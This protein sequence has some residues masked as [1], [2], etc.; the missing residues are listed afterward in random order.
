MNR[1]ALAAAISCTIA[2][3]E[4]AAAPHSPFGGN[5]PGPGPVALFSNGGFENGNL[6]SWTAENFINNGV[7]YPTVNG[8]TVPPQTVAN[9]NLGTGGVANTAAV[10]PAAALSQQPNG[11]S[12]TTTLRWPIY[13]S[14]SAVV[15]GQHDV[16]QLNG[17][18]PYGANQ[19]VNSVK[20]DMV[21]ASTDVD[22][23]DGLAHVRFLVAPVLQNP[24]HTTTQQ[25]Y[26][27]LHVKNLTTGQELFDRFNYVSQ[28]GVPWQSDAAG[29]IEYLAWQAIDVAA[30]GQINVGDDVQA[31]VIASG[32]S[33]GGHWGEAYVDQF[34][35]FLPGIWVVARQPQFANEGT[36]VT[37]AYTVNNAAT[38]AMTNVVVTLPTPN[39]ATFVSFT[40]PASM[41]CTG[42][43]AAGATG[44]ISCTIASMSPFSSVNFSIV[45]Q[46]NTGLTLPADMGNG[47]YGVQS[48][49]QQFLLGMPATTYLTDPA[50]IQ[51]ADYS[52]SIDDG[53]TA[54]SAGQA[55][56]YTVVVK[57][58]GPATPLTN[59]GSV[60]NTKVTETN[61]TGGLTGITWTCT[62]AGTSGGKSSACSAASGSGLVSSNVQLVAGGTATFVVKATAAAP[63]T[64]SFV[65]NTVSVSTS[66]LP[67]GYGDPDSANNTMGDSDAFGTLVNLTVDKD[68]SGVG[69]GLVSSA[70]AGISCASACTTQTAPF[71]IGVQVTLTAVADSGMS[72][73]S[74]T[75]GPCSGSTNPQCSFT[76]AAAV[77][78][79]AKFF[80]PSYAIT[81]TS[82]GNGAL[83]CSTPVFQGQSSTCTISPA[84][85][86]ALSSLTDNG[87]SVLGSVTGGNTYLISNVQAAHTVVAGF[88]KTQ[89]TLCG[90][91]SECGSGNCVDGVCCN[92]SCSGQCQACNVNAGGITPGTCTTISGA[93]V[94]TR[95]ACTSDGSS[96]GGACDGT[97]ATACAYPGASTVCRAASCTSGTQTSAADCNGTGTCPASAT[98]ACSPYVCGATACKISCSTTSDC[99][100]G[101]YCNSSGQCVPTIANG[102]ICSANAQCTNGNCV[103]GV[104]CNSACGAEC[105]ACD[106]A[107]AVGFCSPVSGA[108]HGARAACATDGSSCGGSCD[109]VNVTACA[110][111]TAQ[112]RGA[113]CTGSTETLAA[114]CSG[115]SC[116]AVQTQS[117]NAYVCGAT[118]CKT[119]CGSS[120]DCIAG[121]YCNSSSQC[122]PTIA[123]GGTCSAN[124]QCTNGNCVDGVCCNSACGGECQAC[125]V[126]GA[127]GVCSPVTGAP[128]GSRA[129]CATDGSSCGGS[130]DGTNVSA[131]TYPTT[132]CRSASCSGTTETL[133]ASC[134]GGSCPAVQTQSC[135]TYVCGATAC[136]TSCTSSSDCA[137]GDYCSTGQCV[138]KVVDGGSCSAGSQCTSGYCTDG[139]C[140]DQACNGQCQAC[141]V[142][143]SIGACTTVTT[144]APHGTRAACATDGSSCGGTCNG[145][146]ATACAYPTTACRNASCTSGTATL[147]ASCDG[148]G[149]CP[150]LQ[151]Q[152]CT[153]YVCGATACAG[154][155]TT[156]LDCA[157][158]SWCS[159]GVCVVKLADGSS[160]GASSQCSNGNCVDG[161]C[162]NSAC[163]GQC[164]ACNV[165]GSAGT[166]TAVSGSPHGARTACASD[167][168]ACGG[169]CDGTVRTACAYPGGS[170]TCRA[171]SCTSGVATLAAACNGSGSCPALQTQGCN[172][173]VCGPTACKGNCTVDTD[174]IAGDFCAGGVCAPKLVNGA[175]C[176]A[177]SQCASGQ[178]VDG[179]CCNVVCDGQCEACDVAGSAGTC[180]AVS[181]A[182][183]GVRAACA[184]DGSAC[185]GACNGI[186]INA[187]AFPTVAC[188]GASCALGVA[189]LAAA[190]DGAGH[191]P[192]VQTQTC[193]PYV[194]GGNACAGNCAQPS[195]CAPGDYCAGG[196]CIP[197]LPPG[198]SCGSDA[199]CG[200]GHCV[201]GV[202]CDTACTGQ[203]E[204]CN[205]AGSAGVCSP[206]V[207]AP[208]DGRAACATDGSTCGGA[209]DGSQ[210]AA[211]TYPGSQ[212]RAET[213]CASGVK[214]D[215][216]SCDG[217]GHCPARVQESC[218]PATCTT[219]A[220]CSSSDYC[221]AGTCKPR[222]Q[223]AVAGAGGCTSTGAAA[224]PLLLIVFAFAL[225][226]RKAAL[227]AAV[228]LASGARAQTVSTSFTVD[229]FQPGAGAFDVLG[230]SSPETAHDL[231]WHASAFADYARDPLR[232]IPVG[233]VDPT[234]PSQVRLLRNQSMLHLGGSVGF[235]DNLEIGA[236][237]PIALAQ[238]S[239]SAPMLGGGLQNGVASSG[240]GDLRLLPKIRLFSFG[241][242]VL[243]ASLPLSLPTGRSDAFLSQGS[244]TATPTALFELQRG[245]PVR[246]VANAGVILRSGKQLTN[247]DV[248]NALAYGLAGE[249]PFAVRSQN[250]AAMATLQGEANFSKGGSVERPMELMAAM[251]WTPLAG[252]DLV[253]GGGPGL[254]NG[255]GTPRYRMFFSFAFTPAVLPSRHRL[256]PPPV[257]M[258]AM[259]VPPV[260]VK[261]DSPTIILS[262]PQQS[263]V[264]LVASDLI[265]EE[266][267][268]AKLDTD[269]GKIDL[270]APV[271]FK[272][273]SDV[274]LNESRGVLDSAVTVLQAHPEISRIRIEGHTDN[275]G[276]PAYN[277]VLSQRRATSVLRYLVRHGIAAKR[278][279]ARGFGEEH[280]VA[281]NAT[282]Q[283]RAINR[284]VELLILMTKVASR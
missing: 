220:D 143:S 210:R 71:A 50:V 224:W 128:H 176:S 154:N 211:C 252:L 159:G 194:C 112:C 243:G 105:Q 269:S 227:L 162:C 177:Q 19:N 228:A 216:A 85:G 247:L 99:V 260:L 21:V 185:G 223:W 58:A 30:A 214:T 73:G 192:A 164:E 152:S 76:P 239:G 266:P 163:G 275:Q 193:A 249:L 203:C 135:N 274:L 31:Q 226:R 282:E 284:R 14:Y 259:D 273:D 123:N 35:S 165:A 68:P 229:R 190:C 195:D 169:A 28:A 145:S 225:R 183:H 83:V 8:T 278:L 95:P 257:L 92:T 46:A 144:G 89:G 181:G 70:P 81:A 272:H 57:N 172:P 231:D 114:S 219:D 61:S 166:C 22:P 91:A 42:I 198:G 52:V 87:T 1:L 16:S 232:L 43:P 60:A 151:T 119:S 29:A 75:A 213:A 129:A 147:A 23:M 141:D 191:C 150:T 117:C 250:L 55:L 276:K 186:A 118:A 67:N 218:V 88:L 168:S 10:G 96:C 160:C 244:I 199:Q 122:V 265:A 121:D 139:V 201:D 258:P 175:S 212:C 106:V 235:G 56:T 189:T 188:R 13:G 78:A 54:I 204:A 155:C 6:G 209:C 90:G 116:P 270:L 47:S 113:S 251:R 98:Q 59:K 103:D 4:R 281:S 268:L 86:Y 140:C 66:T 255:Y 25:P 233:P 110:Y 44:T 125:D 170:V 167:G 179:V 173:Y 39:N 208:R 161:L 63:T 33:L 120:S 280:P 100:A 182:P 207:G 221:A 202:C 127:V 271:Q 197:D 267:E 215:A 64:G 142:T 237:L 12:S 108:P 74:W 262:D 133:A 51:Y 18:Y 2:C 37:A 241:G 65:N 24:N 248:G 11:L 283:G 111:P 27:F 222:G 137:A 217:S 48:D 109:G 136:K 3:Q 82:G 261:L 196:V 7:T 32:C 156:N 253:A 238:G 5:R 107:G 130:C 45:W 246:L 171:A 26:Y 102:G 38:S 84:T 41:S 72:F 240:F 69:T 230:V 254:T 256:A 15:N 178:C 9:L 236:V 245:L 79:T 158:G 36:D 97:S 146:S 148:S 187:C 180:T 20:Q 40:P 80:P 53:V 242:V 174:C 263:P 62:A 17:T 138:G 205:V 77:T 157:A 115:G 104:C 124:A 94:G 126:A 200:T 279:E 101:D 132:Q 149:N 277:K 184:S 134:S 234:A 206:V 93:P 131:C 49:Q 34:G 153:P 264:V